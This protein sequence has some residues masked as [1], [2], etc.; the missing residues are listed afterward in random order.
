MVHQTSSSEGIMSKNPVLLNKYA[1]KLTWSF[2]FYS[3]CV[4]AAQLMLLESSFS[5]VLAPV[6]QG[7]LGSS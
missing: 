5:Y 7:G 3:F 6:T 1:S 4:C 2:P